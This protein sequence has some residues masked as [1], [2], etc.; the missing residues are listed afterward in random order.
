MRFVR[1]KNEA[2]QSLLAVHGLRDGLVAM[3]TEVLNR[4]RGL[5]AEFGL[6]YAQSPKAAIAGA[7]EALADERLPALLREVVCDCLSQLADIESR[8]DRWSRRIAEHAK[9]DKRA[10]RLHERLSGVGPLT[11]SAFSASVADARDFKNARQFAAWL[12]LTPR[13]HST[14]GKTRLG[15]LSKQGNGYLRT[16]LVQGARSAL[17]AAQR[18]NIAKLTRLQR[19]IRSIYERRGYHK[20]LAAIANKQARLIWVLLTSDEPLKAHEAVG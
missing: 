14:G 8:I 4:L 12:G 3:R 17:Q 11:A 15:G 10:R 16:L 18:A 19:W 20:T 9:D 7:R 6:T 5:L 13:Q 2:Q 1:I